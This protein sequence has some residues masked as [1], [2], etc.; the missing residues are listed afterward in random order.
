[1]YIY[2]VP[3]SAPGAPTQPSST[4]KAIIIQNEEIKYSCVDTASADRTSTY[5]VSAFAIHGIP[6]HFFP[7][8]SDHKQ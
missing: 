7:K 3:N 8:F 6:L 5:I 1:M 2:M 4:S